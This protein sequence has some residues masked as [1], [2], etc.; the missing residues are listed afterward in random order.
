MVIWKLSKA[1]SVLDTVT[2]FF[3]CHLYFSL[4][5]LNAA[6]MLLSLQAV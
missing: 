3:F 5:K 1:G 2:H 6:F 4:K